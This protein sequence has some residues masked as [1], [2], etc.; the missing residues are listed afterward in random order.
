M[1]SD[2]RTRS[3]SGTIEPTKKWVGESD[4]VAHNS[5]RNFMENHRIGSTLLAALC[6]DD[7]CPH[8]L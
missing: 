3:I 6:K 5:S 4:T 1:S 2:K 8:L 7:L